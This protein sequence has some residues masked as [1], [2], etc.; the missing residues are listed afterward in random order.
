MHSSLCTMHYPIRGMG[1]VLV[2]QAG[3]TQCKARQGLR[4]AGAVRRGTGQTALK[5][6]ICLDVFL[7]S[8]TMATVDGQ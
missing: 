5:V 7:I 8:D 3:A 1:E 2:L 4:K 6:P